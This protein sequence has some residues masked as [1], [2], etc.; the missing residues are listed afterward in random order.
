MYPITH[1]FLLQMQNCILMYR[2]T[3]T[4]THTQS[5]HKTNTPH[6]L[7]HTALLHKAP[8][9]HNL[10]TRSVVHIPPQH[11]GKAS[12]KK[13]RPT[14]Y[15]IPGK[16]RHSPQSHNGHIMLRLCP[17]CNFTPRHLESNHRIQTQPRPGFPH[18]E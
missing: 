15:K 2:F 9:I 14:M 11:L 1:R 17:K 13:M 16:Y 12:N 6:Q 4:H 10:D 5:L 3:P 8:L 7:Y 18:N